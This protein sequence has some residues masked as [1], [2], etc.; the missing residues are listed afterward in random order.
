MIVLGF[1]TAGGDALDSLR[2]QRDVV[3]LDR[4]E[5]A[6]LGVDHHRAR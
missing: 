3:A 4:I 1:D 2:H 6:V 5:N